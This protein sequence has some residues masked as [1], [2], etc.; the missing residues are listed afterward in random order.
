MINEERINILGDISIGATI[1]YQDKLE[2]RPVVVLIMGTGTLD[3]D[4]NGLG[5][6]SNMYKDLSDMFVKMGWICIRYDKRGTHESTGDNKTSGL[7]DLVNDATDVVRYAKKLDYVDED[8]IV[9]CGHSEGAMIATLMTKKEDVQG[10]ILLGGACMGLREAMLYQNYLILEHVNSMKNMIGWYLR[11]VLKKDKIEKQVNG[12]FEKANESNKTRYFYRGMMFNTKYMREH[13]KLT[14]QEYV[15]LLK[16]YRKKVLAIT[17]KSDVQA[18]Y[19]RLDD[20]KEI[21]NIV[22]Y[23]PDKVNHLMREVDNEPNIMNIKKEYKR[24]LKKP[25]S[26]GIKDKIGEWIKDI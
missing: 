6:K 16:E 19:R 22:V 8:R 10:I 24:V 18:D 14:N 2:K 4:G 13:Y 21:D 25:I 20:I 12:L 15:K 26:S 11:K 3:R 5:F 23:T 17:G 1:A 9:V 7:F